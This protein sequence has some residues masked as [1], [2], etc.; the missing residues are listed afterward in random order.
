M[1]TS[2][3]DWSIRNRVV[4]LALAALLLVVGSNAALRSK[5]DV[6]PEFA[7]PEVVV[8]TEA[9]GL[10]PTEVEQLVTSPL[11]TALSGLPRL[12]VI[13]SRSIQGLSVITIVF[14][15]GADIYRARQQVSERLGELAGQLPEGVKPPKMAPLTSATG[16]LVSVGFTSDKLTPQELRDEVQWNVRPRLLAV[17]G[18]ASV[19]LFGG[20]VRQ[21]QV[22]IY[23]ELL[24][25]RGL[26]VTDVLDA[27]RQATG[28]KGAGFIENDRQ[29]LTLR[30]EGQIRSADELGETLLA[31]TGGTPVRLRDVA[32]VAEGPAP[33][34][35]DA[36]IG[37]KPGVILIV[38]KQIDADTPE[39]TRRVEAELQ[40]MRP[41]LEKQSI[42]YH[43]ALF[44]QA[45]F[46]E[47]A[48]G[49][50]THSLV[51]GAALVALVLFVFL[52]NFRTAAI[53]LTAIPLSLL[54]AIAV[55]WTLDVSLNTLTL[56]G[57]AIAVGEVVDDAVIDVENIFRRLRE[58]ARAGHPKSIAAV[59]LSASL[60]V[61]SAVV[62][63]TFIVVLVFVPVFFLTGLQG[64]LFAPLGYAYVL[65]VM[66]SLVVALTVTPAMS[67]FLLPRAEGAEEPPL[68]RR[69]HPG[70]EQ[71]LVRA[72]EQRRTLP[73]ALAQLLDEP[74]ASRRVDLGG[75]VQAVR[76]H[77]RL[78]L[79]QGPVDLR[80]EIEWGGWRIRS[81]LP[82]LRV[83][84]WR[85]G[86]RLAGR[87]KKVQDVFVDAK[88]PRSERE[89][90]PLVVRGDAV[91]AI[92]GVVEAPGVVAVRA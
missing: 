53:S 82:G 70:A 21:F 61:R 56:G 5:L 40:K 55:L 78:W 71:N 30:A 35:G 4:V 17:N 66:A 27:A 31:S 3:V 48:V 11:E 24:A 43:P 7:P 23:P 26:T 85:P 58:N 90:W 51:I 59:V 88:I 81:E 38:A 45:D 19:T 84:G 74:A 2:L 91:V 6:F 41:A 25:A 77:D 86:D 54:G 57:L 10:S 50:V 63:A 79:E 34:F 39:A 47:V 62:Y 15:D 67:M 22:Q 18:V 92:P 36:S 8:Q 33:K 1:L 37:G 32:R 16:R 13:R 52:F 28:V 64:R 68:L 65:A 46:I 49:N 29:R 60:E 87:S 80:G 75:G 83:R 14:K 76:E 44:R 12:D 9:P 20:E 73:P 42:A 69:L 72:L 89:A